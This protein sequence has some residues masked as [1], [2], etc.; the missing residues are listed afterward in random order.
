MISHDS[1]S[2]NISIEKQSAYENAQKIML[3][4]LPELKIEQFINFSVYILLIGHDSF[5]IKGSFVCITGLSQKIVKEYKCIIQGIKDQKN[6]VQW[7]ILNLEVDKVRIDITSQPGTIQIFIPN[8][9]KGIKNRHVEN[10]LILLSILIILISVGKLFHLIEIG[11]PKNAISEYH[12]QTNFDDSI[13]VAKKR[14]D[15]S[16]YNTPVGK[17]QLEAEE[18]E[19]NKLQKEEKERQLKLDKI[20]KKLQPIMSKFSCSE[21]EAIGVL[22]KEIWIGMTVEMLKYNRGLPDRVNVSNYGS[23]D[24]YQA[25]WDDYLPSCFYFKEDQIIYAYN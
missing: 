22:K 21:Q 18:L 16:F 12:N 13:R 8:Q 5:E 11:Q 2:R 6:T 14:E 9:Q 19:K 3:Q 1:L 24:E 25:C 7:S 15:D 20:Y 10:A 17:A 23:G 4:F